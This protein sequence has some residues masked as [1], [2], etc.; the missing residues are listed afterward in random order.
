MKKNS[1]LLGVIAFI[2]LI[3]INLSYHQLKMKDQSTEK[4][5]QS[6][7]FSDTEKTFKSCLIN[8]NPVIGRKKPKSNIPE[9]YCY[10]KQDKRA[11][12][13]CGEVVECISDSKYKGTPC[14]PSICNA[15]DSTCFTSKRK[16]VTA[17]YL[18]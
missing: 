4:F 16:P 18:K 11:D 12:I 15:K 8:Q 10:K 2:I 9:L 17:N 6:Q 5:K 3:V 14:V 13:F 1:V 7:A